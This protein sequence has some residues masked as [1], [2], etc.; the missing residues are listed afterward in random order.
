ME[1]EF[2]NLPVEIQEAMLAEQKRQEG[3]VYP[4]AFREDIAGGFTW[5]EALPVCK[6]LEGE[7]SEIDM[8]SFWYTILIEGDTELF[9]QYF[10]RKPKYKTINIGEEVFNI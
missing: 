6:T 9:F 7:D 1:Q 10:P 5:G 8:G 4:D 3:R 2:D